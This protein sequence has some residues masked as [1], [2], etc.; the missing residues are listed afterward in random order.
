ML[1]DTKLQNMKGIVCFLFFGFQ[2]TDCL[3]GHISDDGNMTVGGRPVVESFDN[4]G[5]FVRWL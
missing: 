3:S 1:F 4:G 5:C 2:I